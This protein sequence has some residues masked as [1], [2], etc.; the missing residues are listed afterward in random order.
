[1][2]F[3]YA[4]KTIIFNFKYKKELNLNKLEKYC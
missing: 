2:Y 4:Y 1:M 3:L